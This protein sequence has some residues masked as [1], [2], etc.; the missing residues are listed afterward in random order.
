MGTH[1]IEVY[2][3]K[4]LVRV[5]WRSSSVGSVSASEA[6]GPEIDPCFSHTFV[7]KIEKSTNLLPVCKLY[8]NTASSVAY[9]G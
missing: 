6:I 4:L 7:E 8:P 9:A 1:L 2:E 5:T 3:Y